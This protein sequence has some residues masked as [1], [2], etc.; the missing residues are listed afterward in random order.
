MQMADGDDDG[1]GDDDDD[2]DLAAHPLL[3]QE[4]T[5]GEGDSGTQA[6]DAR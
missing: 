6:A 2:G 5:H 4:T 3:H 1:G